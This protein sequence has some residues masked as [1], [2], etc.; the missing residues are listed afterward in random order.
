MG[1]ITITETFDL[2]D[3]T[4]NNDQQLKDFRKYKLYFTIIESISFL[5][6]LIC[7]IITLIDFAFIDKYEMIEFFKTPNFIIM[8]ISF[9]IFLI[10]P[11]FIKF[12]GLKGQKIILDLKIQSFK[13]KF[14][15]QYKDYE[16]FDLAE[17]G[18]ENGITSEQM[19]KIFEDFLSIGLIKGELVGNSF[20]LAEN[21]QIRSIEEANFKKFKENIVE[22]I[23]PYRWLSIPKTAKYFHVPYRLALGEIE[24]LIGERKLLGFL[25]GENLVRELSI[26]SL[27]LSDLPE[28]PVCDNKV[29]SSSKY[30]STC[31]KQIN[32]D[33]IMSDLNND[34]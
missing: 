7:G 3:S 17:I 16:K 4:Q 15:K 2:I 33:R 6:F 8:I 14:T 23:K 10:T 25:D 1:L 26:L 30:C 9:I 12:L 32:F 27:E 34:I 22:Y 19:K 11:K 18:K 20:V 28:C 5:A 24:R 13:D 31:G 29:L 21:F